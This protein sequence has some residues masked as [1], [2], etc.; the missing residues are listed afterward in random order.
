MAATYPTTGVQQIGVGTRNCEE[1]FNWYRKHLNMDVPIFD[2][3]A[4]APLMTPYTGGEVHKRRAIL[5]I[6]MQGG[7]GFE[8]WQY[9]SRTPEPAAFD[10]TAGDLG[11]L[12]G[13]I[14]SKNIDASFQQLHAIGATLSE[15]P[16]TDPAGNKH[17][18]VKDPY[19]NIYHITPWDGW[20][21]QADKYGAHG[22]VIGAIMGVSDIDKARTLYSDVLGY[23]T[24]VYDE[25]GVFEDLKGFPGGD[26]KMRR[27][28]LKSSTSRKGAFSTFFTPGCIEL[29]QVM[30]GEHRKILKDR[31][32]GDLG[33][34]HLCFDVSDMKT[35][36]EN[37]EAKGFPFTID[38]ANSF[39]MGEA[40]GRFTYIED[41]DGALIEFVETHKVPIIKKLG[42]FV[43]LQKRGLEKPL[44]RFML[45]ALGLGRVKEK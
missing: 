4:E 42:W 32:W 5:A 16:M 11:I 15:E 38:S 36:Q 6:N 7:G 17:F 44:P 45:N 20:F 25:T 27:V 29:W 8:I 26:R 10:I 30:E 21:K 24:V 34:I 2:D 28:L 22:G 18:F 12:S 39:D 1:A 13:K 33:F 37:C 35:L 31:Y 40:A 14:K 41:P 23:D 43:N 19:N 3:A 9:T